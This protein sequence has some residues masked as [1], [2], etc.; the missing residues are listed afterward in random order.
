MF[1]LFLNI[2]S[3]S[4]KLD[5]SLYSNKKLFGEIGIY[6]A[7]ILILITSIISIIPNEV[8][9]NWMSLNFN[10]GIIQ[11]PSFRSVIWGAFIFW[12]IKC[13]YLYFVG[14]ILFPNKTTNCNF[15]NI[16]ILVGF[17]HAPLLLN[18]I[19][20]NKFLLPLLFINYIWYNVTLIVGLN[21]VLNYKN[22]LK[23]TIIVLAPIIILFLY[24]LKQFIFLNS[25][26][27]IS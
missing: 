1:S 24:T 3:R 15:R 17:A 2:I 27:I 5:K 14:V 23:S 26:S 4:L 22:F 18:I 20:I 11:R 10:L 16:L 19:I 8:V 25:G 21:I 6:F 12:I 13:S 7:I 9:L